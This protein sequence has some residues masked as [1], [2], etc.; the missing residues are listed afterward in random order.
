[1]H[2]AIREL[3]FAITDKVVVMALAITA[4]LAIYTISTGLT[5]SASERAL[6]ERVKAL[7]TEDREFTLAKQGDAGSAAYNAYHLTY[8]APHALSFISRGVRDD[9]PWKHRIRMLALE[10]QIYETD[11]GNP[12][13]SRIGKLDFDFVAAFLLP[14]LS[15]LLLYDLRAAEIRNNRWD[16][17]SATS[18]N[19][20]RL[21]T[22]RAAVRS[23]LLY[24]GIMLPFAIAASLNGVSLTS[25]QVAMSAVALNVFIWFLLALFVTYKTESGPTAAALLLGVWFT[26]AVAIPVLGK[27][28]IED[29]IDLP[30]GGEIL[31]A[32]RETVNAAWDLPKEDTMTPFIK[33]Y[34]EWANEATVDQPFAWKWYFAFHQ[35]GDQTVAPMSEELRQGT[36][37]RDEAMN[38]VSLASPSLRTSRVLS[39]LAETD[40]AS[41]QRYNQ[42]VRQFHAQLREFHYPMLFGRTEY[43]KEQMQQLPTFVPCEAST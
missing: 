38:L 9:L 15:I 25:I 18:G 43:S 11:T 26:T 30:K 21:L 2:S 6:I 22:A 4:I 5:E 39:R 36:R 8:Q 31:L 40:I 23:V 1:M 32:Q 3:R 13:L 14:L 24:L 10:S 29:N 16:F 34:P 42:C 33:Q 37:Q 20:L 19:G 17:L 28:V 7:V 35:V 41:F 27:L 12:E